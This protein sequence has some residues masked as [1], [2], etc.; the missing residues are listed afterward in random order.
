MKIK[1]IDV[2]CTV[3]TSHGTVCFTGNTLLGYLPSKNILGYNSN[4]KPL[5]YFTYINK[6][7]I[8]R[9]ILFFFVFVEFLF[10]ASTT[11]KVRCL[12]IGTYRVFDNVHVSRNHTYGLTYFQL[13][14]LLGVLCLYR[15]QQNVGKVLHLIRMPLY[16][17]IF[18]SS[19]TVRARTHVTAKV[20][21]KSA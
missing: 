18:F 11:G 10:Y 5:S 3:S 21:I 15:I 4:P 20:N 1:H 19:H 12:R 13:V 6:Y 2:S 14:C 7:L 17:L 16:V 9:L 8:W